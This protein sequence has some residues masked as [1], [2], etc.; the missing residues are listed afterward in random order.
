ME[1]FHWAPEDFEGSLGTL[2]IA[3]PPR[4]PHLRVPHEPGRSTVRRR[5]VHHLGRHAEPQEQDE[6]DLVVL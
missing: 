5:A 6:H 2:H 4:P 1:S 3:V